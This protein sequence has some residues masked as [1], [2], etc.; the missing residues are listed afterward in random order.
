MELD[1]FG[2]E[3]GLGERTE[4]RVVAQPRSGFRADSLMSLRS[5]PRAVNTTDLCRRSA[6]CGYVGPNLATSVDGG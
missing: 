2:L 3:F 4:R 6:T 1:A 5:A